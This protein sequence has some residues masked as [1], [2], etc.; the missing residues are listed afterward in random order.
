MFA[1][2]ERH[3][4]LH[5][6]QAKRCVRPA[7]FTQQQRRAHRRGLQHIAVAAAECIKTRVKTRIHTLRPPHRHTFRQMCIHTA[8]P[9][10]LAALGRGVEMHHLRGSMHAGV[11][12]PG[13]NGV[14][15]RTRNAAQSLFQRRLHSSHAASLLLPAVKAAAVIREGQRPTLNGRQCV[16][17]RHGSAF[18]VKRPLYRESCAPSY[19][20]KEYGRMAQRK[21]CP[22]APPLGCILLHA[23]RQAK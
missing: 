13:G 5:G 19:R 7:H 3:S 20:G 23:L 22:P 14:H 6:G 10:L 2:Q 18:K 4:F 8:Y 9:C 17:E 1:H 16:F 12:A 15:R 11:G 21:T